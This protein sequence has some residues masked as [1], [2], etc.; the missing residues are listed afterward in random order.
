[1]S[2]RAVFE[3]KLS[4]YKSSISTLQESDIYIKLFIKL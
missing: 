4:T 1:M 3:K 2:A